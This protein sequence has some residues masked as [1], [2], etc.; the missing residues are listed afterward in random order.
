MLKRG[1]LISL[2]FCAGLYFS[3]EAGAA[4]V[5][6]R[7]FLK[8]DFGAEEILLRTYDPNVLFLVDI[9]SPM[10]FTPQGT[11]PMASDGNTFAGRAEMLKQCTYG[12]GSRPFMTTASGRGL[13]ASELG[14]EAT[15]LNVNAGNSRFGRNVLTTEKTIGNIDDYYSPYD[16]TQAEQAAL[17]YPDALRN[18][19]YPVNT[20]LP[21]WPYFLTFRNSTWARGT[22]LPA[23]YT[24][25]LAVTDPNRLKNELVPNDSRL[26]K[27]KLVLWRM[28]SAKYANML[29]TMKL[30]LAT[31]YQETSYKTTSLVADFYKS[32]TVGSTEGQNGYYGATSTF[33]WG[34]APKWSTGT[35]VDNTGAG[36]NYY[37][38]QRIFSGVYRDY[39]DSTDPRQWKQV[40]R[41]ILQ[42]PFNYLYKQDENGSYKITEKLFDFRRYIDGIEAAKSVPVNT[43]ALAS[44]PEQLPAINPELGADG[45]TPLA[46]SIYGRGTEVGHVGNTDVRGN[47]LILYAYQ[48]LNYGSYSDLILTKMTNSDGLKGGQAVGSAA[49]FFSPLKGS[50]AFNANTAGFFPVLGTCQANWL[51]LFTAGD[52]SGAYPAYQAAWDLF[53]NTQTMRGRVLSTDNKTWEERSF[54][55]DSGVRTLVVGFVDP[56]STSPDVVSLRDKL[57]KIAQFG[58]PV[59]VVNNGVVEYQP[60]LSAKALFANDVPGLIESFS[61]V[62]NRINVAK[63]SSGAPVVTP[64]AGSNNFEIVFGATY[65]IKK[66]DQWQGSMYKTVLSK[67]IITGQKKRVIV[68][69]SSEEMKGQMVNRPLYTSMG[70]EGNTNTAVKKISQLANND[71]RTLADVDANWDK[72]Q[73]WLLTYETEVGS[74]TGLLGDNQ[75]S[76]LLFLGAP[77]AEKLLE[78][79][80]IASRDFGIFMQSNRGI[81]HV[82]DYTTGKERWGFIPPNIFQSRLKGLK[83]DS[84]TGNWFSGNGRSQTRSLPM[85][86]LD[87]KM[88]I[89]DVRFSGNSYRTLL[90]GGLGRG[91]NGLYAMDV[92]NTNA[93]QEPKFLWAIDN[94]RYETAE[95][96]L[97]NGVKLWG[98]AATGA[99]T[100]YDYSDLGLTVHGAYVLNTTAG[101]SVGVLPGGTGYKLGIGGDTQGKIL[102]LFDPETAKVTKKITSVPSKTLGM[103]VGP[104]TELQETSGDTRAFFTSDSEGNVLFCDTTGAASSWVLKSVFQLTTVG[105]ADPYT[106]QVVPEKLPVA[107]PISFQYGRP[108]GAGADEW[109]FG[110]SGNVVAPGFTAGEPRQIENKQQFLFGLNLTKLPSGKFTQDLTSRPYFMDGLIPQYSN[111][112]YNQ[113]SDKLALNGL[114]WYLRLRPAMP[115]T[116]AEYVNVAPL[117]YENVLYVSTF[118]QRILDDNSDLCLALGDSKLYILDPRTGVSLAKDVNGKP[119][120]AYDLKDLK[121]SGMAAHGDNFYI[122]FKE[123]KIGALDKIHIPGLQRVDV[124]PMM[125]G[126]RVKNDADP[127]QLFDP[128]IQYRKERR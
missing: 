64:E 7:P 103:L 22:G 34:I 80:S 86:L 123:L 12:D 48:N 104:L 52:D 33:K 73:K 97:L 11:I 46:A 51:V 110:G 125:E 44:T 15:D 66:Y 113:A 87:G 38:S 124:L 75:H 35:G 105:T 116:E 122:A 102:Y 120:A 19:G 8:S 47:P 108:A 4:P 93:G 72:F 85:N 121:V 107:I 24:L 14:N 58:D 82:F 117:L 32:A 23:G 9:G 99:K 61:E 42:T 90:L 3:T 71:F 77:T 27:L 126:K 1:I 83:F 76:E 37:M 78:I 91:G 98:N 63:M 106:H 53:M 55:M 100:N 128:K 115:G 81:L 17:G 5:T 109:L 31:S 6:L 79:S 29:S 67:D 28:T 26:Y 18:L 94:A 65:N 127:I 92:T 118:I 39:Y 2:L 111:K 16:L 41:S 20:Y 56:K 30:A 88:F 54:A 74:E 21:Y 96:T 119:I 101:Q 13:L 95:P 112:P 36:Q 62:L 57:T 69:D 25:G 84:S 60:N 50:L 59:E 68:W 49:D 10:L 40:N 89:R 70:K 114:G 43:A 45:K